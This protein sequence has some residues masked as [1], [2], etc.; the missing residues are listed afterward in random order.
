MKRAAGERHL[1][2][3]AFTK[4]Y[5]VK[6]TALLLI[7]ALTVV[8]CGKEAALSRALSDLNYDSLPA[9]APRPTKP[10]EKLHAAVAELKGLLAAQ[11]K[12][13]L[14]GAQA[15][16]ARGARTRIAS[17]LGALERQFD[18][19]RAKLEDHHASAA[20][21]R[22]AKIR[23]RTAS[24]KRSLETALARVPADGAHSAAPVASATRALAALSPN[25]P[26]QPLSTGFGDRGATHR[27]ASLSAG[28]TPAYN[29]PTATETPSDLPRTPEP[30]DLGETPETKVTPAVHALA[31]R[32]GGDPVRIYAYVRNNIR[33]EPYYGIRKGADETLA[34]R[35]GSDA[36]QA[37][38]LIALL[39]DAGVNARF[40]RGTAELPADRAANWLG[41]DTANGE[42]P[43][44]A[45]D[46]LA[47]G[48]V[49]TTQVRANGALVKVRFE[50]VWAEAYVPGGAYR[51]IDEGL[52]GK[53]WLPLD[54]SIKENTLKRPATDFQALLKPAIQDWARGF[55]DSSQKVGD[56]GIVAPPLAET[57]AKT[58]ALMNDAKR[59]LE[60]HG[61]NNGSSLDEVIGATRIKTVVGTY[62][63]STT[64]FRART[65]SG[66]LRTLPSS[67]NASVSVVVSGA[68]P[69]SAPSVDPDAPNDAGFAFTAPTV[70]L[71]NKRI[72]LAY[73]PASA[74]DAEVIDAY[75]GLLNAPSYAA[76]LTPV[77][78]VDGRVVARGHQAVS[79]GYTQNLKIT[80]RMPGYSADVVENPLYVG[81]LSA[82]ALDLG[83]TSP[84]QLKA[85]GTRLAQLSDTTSAN[86]L[87]DARAG[88][89]LSILGSYYFARN[90][91]F[92]ELAA[93][94][95]GI[96]RS[97]LLSGGIAASATGVSYLAGF[98]IS[99][100]FS[101]F[102]IDV[103]EDAQSI[104][105]KTGNDQVRANYLR[106]MGIQASA[107]ESDIF[108]Q[109]MHRDTA[110]TAAVMR[111]AMARGET[112]LR[113]DASNVARL[114]A[115]AHVAA[116]VKEQITRAVTDRGATVFIPATE[117]TIGS[118]SGAGYIVDEGS[119]IEY[120]I[121]GGLSGGAIGMSLTA[122]V[123]AFNDFTLAVTEGD[124][125]C[126]V[127]AAPLELVGVGTL[128]L[129]PLLVLA[130]GAGVA[131]WLVAL[132]LMLMVTAV[133]IHLASIFGLCD[134]IDPRESP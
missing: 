88:E 104:V 96:D 71:A 41:V 125:D 24:L 107:S 114:D 103:D 66:E 101:G 29:S 45:A 100:R 124:L 61:I 5:P 3:E 109:T 93:Q 90:D 118:W 54:P 33:Y 87:T 121:S 64:P 55:V 115:L 73:V 4:A 30:A 46:I 34:E 50:H 39:R 80:Y 84:A 116:G 14:S 47:S 60:D 92:D 117:T 36:D 16:H 6:V 89:M 94:G 26:Q 58:Q 85:R 56:D 51:G 82:L 1:F 112:I 12:G 99:A 122:A 40:V 63:P 78:R 15:D 35:A 59:V 132:A 65:V 133:L 38:L 91:Q 11:A 8:S 110:S 43:D 108:S 67:L 20:L 75:H 106:A 70:D 74:T 127:I 128:M 131:G 105:S 49:P 69:L 9:K 62:L 22:L 130:L 27:P 53:T 97:R 28:I 13:D 42:R 32:L 76:A 79:T 37:A 111:D 129:E 77:L 98:P 21:A 86:L 17:E 23:N 7:A 44:A 72:T 134:W 10:A 2:W 57:S 126:E 113:I 81:S 68:D 25:K 52:S 102:S 123:G 119:T 31:Q 18:A 120:R 19:D 48:G 83:S 95:S